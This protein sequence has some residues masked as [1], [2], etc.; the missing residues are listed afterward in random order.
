MKY[1]KKLLIIITVCAVCACAVL[2]VN[3]DRSL[4]YADRVPSRVVMA[5]NMQDS[6]KD[7]EYVQPSALILYSPGNEM[8]SKYENNIRLVLR[9]LRYDSESLDIRRADTVSYTDYDLIVIASDK[10]EEELP[11]SARRLISY[12]EGGGRLFW[13]I[14]QDTPGEQFRSIYRKMGIREYG[15]Y[16]DYQKFVIERELLPGM[17]GSEFE[18]E[19]FGDV[20]LGVSLNDQADVYATAVAGEKKAPLIW[21]QEIG[22]GAIVVFNGTGITGDFWRGTIAGCINALN[23]TVIYP[24]INAKCIFIDDFPSPQ[25]E[26]DSEVLKEEYN[27]T[28]GEFYRD[29]WWPDMQKIAKQTGD[30]YTGLFVATYN[31]IVNPDDFYYEQNSMEQY[32]GNSL[33]KN[34]YELG[35]HGYNHQSL[36]ERGDVPAELGYKS[37]KDL[38]DMQTSI[39]ELAQ[40]SDELFPGNEM[41]TYVPPSNYLSDAGR[42]AVKRALPDLK[43]ISG[44]YTQE[45]EEGTVYAKDFTMSEDGIAE[46]PRVTS[47]MIPDDF[48]KFEYQNALG[49]HGVFSHFIHPDDLFD[50]DRSGGNDWETMYKEYCKMMN[51]IKQRYPGIRSLKASEAADALKVAEELKV[52]YRVEGETLAGTCGNFYGEAYLYLKTDKEPVAADDSCE[53]RR[54]DPV[55]GELYYLVKVRKPNFTIRLKER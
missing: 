37:W 17:C 41:R 53:V 4:K 55:N 47:G 44:V 32:Y 39:E 18:G 50:P 35:A 7:A 51:E 40:I 29:I 49:L 14:L 8:S 10:L 15:E 6:V 46:F 28:V 25:Y 52:D 26:N 23:D 38:S 45:G 43:A 20:S 16:M 34:G 36:A 11:D 31:D 24:V 13:G 33:L 48:T 19:G 27:R 2:F 12:A 21:R 5:E 3:A 1:I 22:E 9:H 42:E 30:I 54:S